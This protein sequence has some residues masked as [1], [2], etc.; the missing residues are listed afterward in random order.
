MESSSQHQAI[1]QMLH[2]ARLAT[3]CAT[4]LAADELEDAA[5]HAVELPDL[6]RQASAT[7][8]EAIKPC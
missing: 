4:A 5:Q 8:L 3:D 2:L 7:V 6:A 1:Q